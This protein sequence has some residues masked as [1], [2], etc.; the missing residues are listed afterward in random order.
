LS[1]HRLEDEKFE[2]IGDAY[3]SGL[4][5]GEAFRPRKPWSI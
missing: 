3:V 5:N 4:R 1:E 2:I